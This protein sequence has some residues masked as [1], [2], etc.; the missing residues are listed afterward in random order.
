MTKSQFNKIKNNKKVTVFVGSNYGGIH[1]EKQILNIKDDY[2]MVF[3]TKKE[4]L[5]YA[6]K[7]EKKKLLKRL[8][9]VRETI[10][11]NS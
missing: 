4:A 6:A 5:L 1:A 8:K 7:E 9:A 2:K 11:K 10:A 3:L